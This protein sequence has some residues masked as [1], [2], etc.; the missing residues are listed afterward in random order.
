MSPT[1][2][3]SDRFLVEKFLQIIKIIAQA[4]DTW[5]PDVIVLQQQD[6]HSLEDSKTWTEGGGVCLVPTFL[7]P[8]IVLM[9]LNIVLQTKNAAKQDTVPEVPAKKKM[10]LKFQQQICNN[11]SL[12]F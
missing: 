1:P 12:Y 8:M 7:L 4:T 3:V 6:G 2:K 9:E 5:L 11:Y 10:V